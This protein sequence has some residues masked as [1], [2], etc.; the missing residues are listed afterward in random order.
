[1]PRPDEKRPLEMGPSAGR[2]VGTVP[3]VESRVTPTNVENKV[4][5]RWEAPIPEWLWTWAGLVKVGRDK[6][7]SG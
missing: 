5:C 2:K 6:H 7:S 1:M 4:P 3:D